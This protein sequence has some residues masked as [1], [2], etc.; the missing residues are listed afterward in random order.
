M[1]LPSILLSTLLTSCLANGASPSAQPTTQR[2]VTTTPSP[3]VP[4]VEVIVS[5]PDGA[6][7]A[8]QTAE[9]ASVVKNNM[10]TEMT[11]S[12]RLDLPPAL[13]LVGGQPSW[14]GKVPP[15]GSIEAIRVEVKSVAT[16]SWTVNVPYHVTPNEPTGYGGNGNSRIYVSISQNSAEWRINPAYDAPRGAGRPE[17]KPTS[18][19]PPPATSPPVT[20]QPVPSS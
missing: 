3:P 10:R 14:E 9:L 13:E 1:L 2:P 19:P 6:P 12:V 7:P 15:N 17:D 5:F 4:P 20:A 16:G 18:R 8:N 11:I